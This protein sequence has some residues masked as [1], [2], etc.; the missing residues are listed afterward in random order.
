MVVFDFMPILV[1]GDMPGKWP[2]EHAGCGWW[3]V[4]MLLFSMGLQRLKT[5]MEG[6]MLVPF[7]KNKLVVSDRRLDARFLVSLFL[8][9]DCCI[10][11]L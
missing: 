1:S 9:S 8:S 2:P 6:G 7:P 3:L 11:L 10:V 4:A 5:K